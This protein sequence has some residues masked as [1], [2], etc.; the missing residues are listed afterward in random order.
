MEFAAPKAESLSLYATEDHAE[1]NSAQKR[2]RDCRWHAE[3][4]SSEYCSNRD[5][6]PYTGKSGFTPGSWCPECALYKLRRQH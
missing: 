2:F 1:M 6:L 5:V 4:D 3:E